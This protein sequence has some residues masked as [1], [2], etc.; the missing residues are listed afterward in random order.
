VGAGDF[1]TVSPVME[2]GEPSLKPE[3]LLRGASTVAATA[4]RPVT[5]S[6]AGDLTVHVTYPIVLL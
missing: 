5:S 3:W 1:G 6:Q 2:G 4:A